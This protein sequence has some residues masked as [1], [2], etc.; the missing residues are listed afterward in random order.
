M[1]V[2]IA[3]TLTCCHSERA[4]SPEESAFAGGTADSSE[5]LRRSE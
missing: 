5:A 4:G 2:E 3:A 1:K